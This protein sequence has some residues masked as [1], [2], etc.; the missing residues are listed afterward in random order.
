MN[1]KLHLLSHLSERSSEP[2]RCFMLL[3]TLLIFNPSSE[4]LPPLK[5]CPETAGLKMSI[6]E[7]W[8]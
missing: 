6:R 1:T 2:E 8:T 5:K 3:E 7:G 4:L